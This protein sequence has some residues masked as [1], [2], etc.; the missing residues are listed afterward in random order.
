MVDL[1]DGLMTTRAMRRFS[2]EPVGTDEVERILRAAQ[3]APSGGNIQ[4]WQ[5]V[6]VTDDDGR[7]WLGDLY[8]RAYARYEAA[9]MAGLPEF[10]SDDDREA[11]ERTV[12]ASRHLADH[13]GEVPVI[14]LVCMPDI[15]MSV[16]DDDG[17]MDVGTPFASVYPAVQNLLLA[18]RSMG[19]GGL[20]TT[21]HRIHHDEVRGHFGIP[22]GQQVVALVPL[23]RPTGRFG[24]ARRRPVDRVTHWDHWGERRAATVPPYQPPPGDGGRAT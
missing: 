9:L 17:E 24:V 4:P 8:R 1:Y 19:I 20:I 16:R 23:G 14:V 15:S 21:V 6:V 3:Q 22:D 10:R 13:L 2:R 18:A 12:R 11:W 7:A 5:F